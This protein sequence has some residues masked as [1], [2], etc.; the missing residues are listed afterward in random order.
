M[1]SHW[2]LGNSWA[3][4]GSWVNACFLIHKKSPAKFDT[5]LIF[6]DRMGFKS[7]DQN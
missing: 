2:G 7:S 4:I 1:I 6:T 3:V 5:T